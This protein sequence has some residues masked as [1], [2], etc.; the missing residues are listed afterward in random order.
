MCIKGGVVHRQKHELCTDV[1]EVYLNVLDFS[2]ENSFA[3]YYYY[4]LIPYIYY[5]EDKSAQYFL[6]KESIFRRH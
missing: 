2:T 6:E 4:F 5:L 1:F 3:Y